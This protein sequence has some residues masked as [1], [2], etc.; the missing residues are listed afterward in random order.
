[1]L[2][3]NETELAHQEVGCKDELWM[4]RESLGKTL[5]HIGT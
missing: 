2:N 5:S 3:S 4:E 1:M